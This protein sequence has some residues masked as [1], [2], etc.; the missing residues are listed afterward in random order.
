MSARNEGDSFDAPPQRGQLPWRKLV[1]MSRG[2]L[3]HH[4]TASALQMLTI[5]A[6]AAFLVFV[7]GEIITTRAAREL[8]AAA[9]EAGGNMAHLIWMLAIA[10]L[11]CAISNVMSMLLSVTRRFREIGT[12]KC[13]GAFDRTVLLLFMVDIGH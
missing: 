7:L 5:A 8:P 4:M 10:L 2:S 1:R 13:L 6:T 3:R 12:M 9:A 11:V